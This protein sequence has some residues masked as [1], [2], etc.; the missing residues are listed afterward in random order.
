MTVLITGA[1]R[2][3][4][5]H[6]ALGLAARGFSVGVLG[7]DRAGLESVVDECRVAGGNALAV[8]ADVIDRDAVTGAV[9]Q[10]VDEFGG[11][12]LLI[13]NAAAIES[14]EAQ[15][16]G[17]DVDETWRVVEVNVRGP[18]LVTHAVLPH[19]RAGGGGRIVNINSGSGYR[20]GPIYTGYGVSKGA[21]AQFTRH[22]ARQYESQ[23]I[24]AFDVAPGVV[25]TD[26]TASMPVHADRTEWTPASAVVELVAEIGQGQLDELSGR[27]LRAGVDTAA[28]LLERSEEIVQR[29][30]RIVRLVP[31][32]DADPLG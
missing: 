16:G 29:D 21:L 9:Q 8:V 7:R 22:L 14:V 24:A 23:G 28:S 18:M 5:R 3:I 6:I 19:M 27:F 11:I 17:V 30:A 20:A 10:V 15:F 13:N 26:M 32:D 2:G 31:I 12:D 25:Q 1:N 4:G